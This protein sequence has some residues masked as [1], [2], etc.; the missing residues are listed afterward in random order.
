MKVVYKS[1]SERELGG[2]K[3]VDLTTFKSNFLCREIYVIHCIS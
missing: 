1:I 2:L 3:S